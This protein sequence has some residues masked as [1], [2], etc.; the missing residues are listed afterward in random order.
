MVGI[1]E[2]LAIR[3][4]GNRLASRIAPVIFLFNGGFGFINFF[5]DLS[6]SKGLLGTLADL[7]RTYTMNAT[8]SNAF[9]A[10]TFGLGKCFHD[11]HHSAALS[12]LR[13][14]V[15][16]IDRRPLVDSPS[17]KDRDSC[18]AAFAPGVGSSRRLPANAARTQLLRHRDRECRFLYVLF[19]SFDW[20]AFLIPLAI[21]AAPQALFLMGDTGTESSVLETSG[22]GVG[23]GL[24][25]SFLA[26]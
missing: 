7:P 24:S 17:R 9:W 5:S 20:L 25:G 16:G 14:S 12:A 19:W 15:S 10:N 2:M 22:L 4:T 6:L 3:L 1:I 8:L 13:P 18:K 21:F 26:G 23:N 11:A